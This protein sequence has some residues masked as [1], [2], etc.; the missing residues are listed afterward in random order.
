[1]LGSATPDVVSTYRAL[2]GD[3][4]L[5]GLP[6]R[7]LGHARH[8]QEQAERHHVQTS[9]QALAGD[10]RMIDLPPVDVVDMRQE[11]RVGNLTMFSRKLQAAL[12]ETLA[13]QEQAILFLN[14]RGAATYVFCRDCG[15]TLT[16]PHCALPLTQH[17][18]AEQL[19]CHHCNY[20][21]PPPKKCP[22]CQ[23]PRIRFFGAGTQ[24]VEEAVRTLFPQAVPLRWDR[25]ATRFK[26]AHDLILQQFSQHQADVLIGTQMIAK[27]LDLPLVTLV[28]VI[29]ADVGLGLPD[30]HAAERTFQILTQVAGRAGR[31][32]LGGRVI[33]QTYQPDHYALQAAAGHDYAGFYAREVAQRRDLNY[34]PFCRLLRLIYRHARAD[35]AEAEAR[36]MAQQLQWRL[37]EAPQ[38]ELAGPTPCF[39]EKISGEYRWQIILRA[40][41][42][43]QFVAGLNLKGWYVD[44]DPVSL[45]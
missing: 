21:R 43:A 44:V 6:K 8:I 2:R 36:L 31:S 40:P 39:F 28:G 10:A 11:L 27:G 20:R 9:Y 16:C 14:R 35:H 7:I 18:L 22:H 30:Y 37:S 1:V 41:Q 15:Q 5:L 42:P 33:L 23:S 29:S 25:D 4:L 17:S 38:A 3:Y 45:L 32:L 12:R 19:I 13:R 24:K 34:P 26:G